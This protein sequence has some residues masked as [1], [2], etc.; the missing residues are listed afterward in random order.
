MIDV[1]TAFGYY[2]IYKN[3]TGNDREEYDAACFKRGKSAAER[4]PMQNIGRSPMSFF[5]EQIDFPSSRR[6]RTSVI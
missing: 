1:S 3:L 4:F 5:C 6:R 2:K